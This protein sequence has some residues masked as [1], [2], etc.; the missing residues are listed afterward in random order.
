MIKRLDWTSGLLMAAGVVVLAGSAMRRRTRRFDFR[1]KVVLIAG[2]SR[3]LGLEIARQAAAEGASVA[4][5]ARDERELQ[6]AGAEIKAA[7]G[8]VL[9]IPCDLR[10][11]PRADAAVQLVIDELGGI[12][13]LINCAGIITVGPL[14][15]MT[16]EDIRDCMDANFWSAVHTCLA[17]IPEMKR[18]GGGRIANISSIG[19]K[20]AVP[21]LLPYCASKFAL[22]GFSRA[23]RT[24]LAKED[25]L[26]TTVCP[27]LMRTGSPRHAYFKGQNEKEYAWFSIADSTPGISMSSENAA[28][29]ILEATRRGDV[30]LVLTLS[31][32][33]AVFLDTLAPELSGELLSLGARL[34]PGPGGIGSQT[35][36]G[37]ESESRWAPSVLTRLS[38]RAAQRN[39]E[40]PA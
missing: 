35:A 40:L 34:L 22:T 29:Q 37:S 20:V 21:H 30:E 19:G 13:V 32:K 33:L 25:V 8:N 4:L 27:G 31:A 6:I 5:L 7:G 15:T 38:D 23:L 10:L 1:D 11:K 16:I 17:A 12:D 2:G 24:E 3:G 26:V 9:T 14:E 39:N 18:R 28:R 36:T